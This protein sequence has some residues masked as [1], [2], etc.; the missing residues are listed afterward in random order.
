MRS[1]SAGGKYPIGSSSRSL[2]YRLTH[3]RVLSSTRSTLRP[4]NLIRSAKLSILPLELFHT[5]LLGCRRPRLIAR[6]PL[7]PT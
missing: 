4:E 1:Y 2:L 3:S 6:V 5:V 7:D